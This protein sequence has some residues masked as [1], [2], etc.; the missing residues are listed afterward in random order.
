ML[1]LGAVPL[2]DPCIRR[3]VRHTKASTFVAQLS[4]GSCVHESGSLGRVTARPP[5]SCRATLASGTGARNGGADAG[6]RRPSAMR[7]RLPTDAGLALASERLGPAV[8]QTLAHLRST[9]RRCADC[10]IRLSQ[11]TLR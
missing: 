10:S 4:H 6:R 8:V 9:L 7:V 3:C 11:S 1:A 5:R 2:D